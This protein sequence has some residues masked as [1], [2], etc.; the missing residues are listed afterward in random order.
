[1]T[2]AILTAVV[3]ALAVPGVFGLRA[4]WA[5]LL[6]GAI[7]FNFPEYALIAFGAVLLV[8]IVW[9]IL[10]SKKN[11]VDSKIIDGKK[12]EDGTWTFQ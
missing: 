1:M 9:R 5:G 8:F 7:A 4:W 10:D 6:A 12:G 3:A 2:N 11:R